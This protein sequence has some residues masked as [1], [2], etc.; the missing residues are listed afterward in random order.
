MEKTLF[1]DLIQ[2]LNEAISYA[3][4][5]ISQGRSKIVTIPDDEIEINQMIYQQICK[6]SKEN[7]VKIISYANDLLQASL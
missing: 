6:L 3:N 4:G 1:T 5:D 2:S 7:K